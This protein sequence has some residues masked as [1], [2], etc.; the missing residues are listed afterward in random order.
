LPLTLTPFTL[1]LRAPELALERETGLKLGARSDHFRVQL[2]EP[3]E[4]THGVHLA[5][6]EMPQHVPACMKKNRKEGP[7]G[8]GIENEKPKRR[9]AVTREQRETPRETWQKRARTREV[10]TDK[11]WNEPDG[12]GDQEMPRYPEGLALHNGAG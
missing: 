5:Q 3:E 7:T 9:E 1:L 12:G 10:H 6:K 4:T 2:G 11:K 8:H